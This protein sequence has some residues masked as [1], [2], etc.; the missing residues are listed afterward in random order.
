M[1]TTTE[2]P[3]FQRFSGR[4]QTPLWAFVILFAVMD[5]TTTWIGITYFGAHEGNPV[6]ASLMADFGTVGAMVAL[7]GFALAVGY[8]CGVVL[9]ER[10][11][12]IVPLGLLLP[13]GF[14]ALSNAVLL[15]LAL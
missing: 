2:S 14:A 12:F 7:K 9:P 1:A 6:A 3:A 11:R 15:A 5:V 4:I 8:L 13:W 10:Y